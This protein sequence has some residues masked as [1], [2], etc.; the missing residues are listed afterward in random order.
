VEIQHG[1]NGK[2]YFMNS[3]I[4]RIYRNKKVLITG[5]TGFKGSW[6][7]HWLLL[8]EAKVYGYALE[9]PTSPSLYEQLGNARKIESD[10]NDIR[11]F[12]SIK[13]FIGEVK[14]D[15]IFHLAAQSLVRESY[16]NPLETLETNVTGTANLL[17]AVRQLK[18]STNIVVITSDKCYD[19]KEWIYGYREN[20]A[21][22]GYDPYSASKGAA[23]IVVSSWR[24]SFFNPINYNKHKVKLAS[25]RAGNVIGGGDWANDRIL[26]DCIRALQKN[27]TIQIRNPLA[28]RPWQHVLESLGGYLLLGSKLMDVSSNNLE[29]LCSGF[30]F[31]PYNTSNKKVEVLVEEVLKHWEGSWDYN[32]EDALHEAFLLNL[33]IDKAFQI[34]EW[35]PVWNFKTTIEKTVSWYKNSFDNPEEI[36]I[37][38]EEQIK[39]YSNFFNNK[40]NSI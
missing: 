21:F 37:K 10:I 11:D 4:F 2:K 1:K 14:P 39:E 7:T 35:S 38:T 30:N 22:G 6:L 3:G 29:A 13:K 33:T 28:T 24:N 23:E 5:H 8:L 18:L 15:I 12:K 20:D 19:N 34:L 9:A 36:R 25:A 40:I 27:K 31:G 17:E 32:K 16:E 26:P